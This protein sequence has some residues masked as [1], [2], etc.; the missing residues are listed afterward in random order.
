MNEMN[1]FVDDLYGGGYLEHYGVKGMKWGQHKE[2]PPSPYDLNANRRVYDSLGTGA[3]I[4]TKD[5]IQFRYEY[6]NGSS[7]PTAMRAVLSPGDAKHVDTVSKYAVANPGKITANGPKMSAIEAKHLETLERQSREGI[8]STSKATVSK[9]RNTIKKGKAA[10]N[11]ILKGLSNSIS[12]KPK[13]KVRNTTI[14]KHK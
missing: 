2:Y 10:V 11:N 7:T 6:A 3:N 8:P 12:K 13:A 5:P 9:I 14:K 4:H 1:Q